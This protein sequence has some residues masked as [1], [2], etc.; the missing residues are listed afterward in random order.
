MAQRERF[1]K[2]KFIHLYRYITRLGIYTRIIHILNFT[3]LSPTNVSFSTKAKRQS[4]K[5][6]QK[7]FKPC[8]PT[9]SFHVYVHMT[10]TILWEIALLELE[11]KRFLFASPRTYHGITNV[12]M[13]K[14]YMVSFPFVTFLLLSILFLKA[15]V[16]S[17]VKTKKISTEP[18]HTTN[19]WCHAQEGYL[20]FVR[21]KGLDTTSGARPPPR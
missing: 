11:Q 5:E 7:I 15:T 4:K 13:T 9:M 10:K 3:L 8:C 20:L 17:K 2:Y 12:T 16:T 6:T 1:H 21:E 18:K 14:V 19:S